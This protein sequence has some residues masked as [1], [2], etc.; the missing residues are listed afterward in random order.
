MSAR[1]KYYIKAIVPKT[2]WYE[3]EGVTSDEAV[4]NLRKDINVITV[5]ETTLD[6]TRVVESFDNE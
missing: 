5:L 3:S 6:P 4:E 1:T 2:Q